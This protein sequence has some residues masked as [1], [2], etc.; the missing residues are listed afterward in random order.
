MLPALKKKDFAS[1]SLSCF[2]HSTKIIYRCLINITL[3]RASMLVTVMAPGTTL[4][5][6]ALPPDPITIIKNKKKI[7]P[8]KIFF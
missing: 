4:T 8:K 7:P 2:D 6:S 3:S 1:Q 5:F